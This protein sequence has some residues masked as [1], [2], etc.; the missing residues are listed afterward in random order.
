MPHGFQK[1]CVSY[2]ILK[3]DQFLLLFT[4]YFSLPKY[5]L[6]DLFAGNT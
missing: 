6:H 2:W 4:A 3:Y 5:L 1:I